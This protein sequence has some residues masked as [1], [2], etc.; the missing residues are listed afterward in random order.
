MLCPIKAAMGL[1][2]AALDAMRDRAWAGIK[3]RVP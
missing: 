2:D 3:G 1:L